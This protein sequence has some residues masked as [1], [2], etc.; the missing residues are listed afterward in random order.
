MSSTEFDSTK[1]QL[2]GQALEVLATHKYNEK[3][4]EDRELQVFKETSELE[5]QNLRRNAA[6]H[7]MQHNIYPQKWLDQ[8]AAKIVAHPELSPSAPADHEWSFRELSQHGNLDI[9]QYVDLYTKIH[10]R[11]KQISIDSAA[12]WVDQREVMYLKHTD[13][14]AG[15][16]IGTDNIQQ[17]VA[18]IVE[19]TDN[20]GQNQVALA[21]IDKFTT[22]DSLKQ[23][24]ARF[25]NI[26]DVQ[27]ISYG[28]RDQVL[29]KQVSDDNIKLV[30]GVIEELKIQHYT[31]TY[32]EDAVSSHIIFDPQASASE[33][34]FTYTLI[35][36]GGSE[37]KNFRSAARQALDV[38]TKHNISDTNP[39]IRDSDLR[40]RNLS[41]ASGE[42]RL[43]LTHE[44]RTTLI[45]HYDQ[46]Y[47]SKL[48][49]LDT[50][51][52][53][54]KM[55]SYC[56]ESFKPFIEGTKQA[57]NEMGYHDITTTE[58]Y[59]YSPRTV[60]LGKNPI[61]KAPPKPAMSPQQKPEA[62]AQHP[63][64]ATKEVFQPDATSMQVELTS[65]RVKPTPP[66]KP[67]NLKAHTA[68]LDPTR[69]L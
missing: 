8:N 61:P 33:P 39:S 56:A 51:I 62:P 38:E 21:H 1:Q 49:E 17:C 19:G 4:I 52:N 31:T 27:A 57:L 10:R 25:N 30:N 65:P 60:E 59:N 22:A 47:H 23:V 24:F 5:A 15:I 58:L 16:K 66:P 32:Q 67:P 7:A 9:A 42:S 45:K 48:L 55:P 44:E 29:H 20:A 34:K 63:S 50:A 41:Q 14:A 26:Q 13:I 12:Y 37:T 64:H 53:D 54:P 40:E 18:V 36:D 43:V 11:T 68:N 6:L 28:A 35:P 69:K 46:L 3:W 2:I